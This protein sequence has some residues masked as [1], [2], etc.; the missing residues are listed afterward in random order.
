MNPTDVKELSS[1]YLRS[2]YFPG[3]KIGL[4]ALRTDH[5][6]EDAFRSMLEGQDVSIVTNRILFNDP[7]NT[8]NLRAMAE[9]LQRA[10]ADLL[11]EKP[12]DVVAFGC[13]S[14]A[15]AIGEE[16]LEKM[17]QAIK[18]G[19]KV[20]NPVTAATAAFKALKVN[21]ISMITP[22]IA[23]VNREVATFFTSKGLDVLSIAGFNVLADADIT[24]IDPAAIV[25]AATKYVHPESEA[26]FLSCTAL[27]A[28]E[29]IDLLE[30]QLGIP[31][32]T[33]NQAMAWHALQLLDVARPRR[34]GGELFKCSLKE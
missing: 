7:V 12:I 17:I 25:A 23:E 8:E 1:N 28:T 14:G 29:V 3:K 4:I 27:R 16:R 21:R 34:S 22:Y 10:T 32:V 2:E 33:S 26:L 9:D 31:V 13:S 30:E 18:P 24:R 19:A 5:L 20:T 11:P 6:V 15:T